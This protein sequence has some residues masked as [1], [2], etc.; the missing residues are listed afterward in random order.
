MVECFSFNAIIGTGLLL[1]SD[2]VVFHEPLLFQQANTHTKSHF[3]TEIVR[4]FTFEGF[5]I[6]SS[7]LCMALSAA[8]QAHIVHTHVCTLFANIGVDIVCIKTSNFRV[9]I[10]RELCA[11]QLVNHHFAK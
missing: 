7:S 8:H 1:C 2:A 6:S 5:L 10:L 11:H 3:R 4:G 9:E